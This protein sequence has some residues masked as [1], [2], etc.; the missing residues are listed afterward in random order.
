[1]ACFVRMNKLHTPYTRNNTHHAYFFLLS[2]YIDLFCKPNKTCDNVGMNVFQRHP[3]QTALILGAICVFGFAPFYIFPIPILALSGLFYLWKHTQHARQAAKIG[4]A[5]G[6]GFFT[7]GIS[8]IYISLHDVGGMPWWMA[9]TATFGLCAFLSLFHAACG[10][11]TRRI[12][13]VI[14][15]APILWT[16]LEWVREWLFTGFPWLQIGYS[17][18]PYS[19]LANLA[20][21]T[22]ILGV[23]FAVAA[24][25]SLIL[26]WQQH[27]RH[28]L[29]LWGIATLLG[30]ITWTS[31]TGQQIDVTLL[32]GNVPQTLKWDAEV[33]EQTSL[34]YYHMMQQSTADLVVM[35]E[36]ALP[37]AVPSEEI[38]Q[39]PV[40]G[41]FASYAKQHQVHVVTGAIEVE[42][43]QYY[44]SMLALLPNGTV[45]HYRKSHLVPFGEFIPFKRGLDWLYRDWLHIPMSDLSRGS[46]V[47]NFSFADMY[48][49]FNICYE[50]VFGSQIRR[51]LPQ[52]NL[53]INASNDAWYGHSLAAYQHLQF[54]QAR[55]LETGR[56]LLRATNTG[57]TAAIN[58]HGV[59]VAV[60]P[61][62][63]QASLDITAPAYTGT[64]PYVLLGNWLILVLL[65][66]ALLLLWASKN[67]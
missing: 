61:D 4:F 38:K 63:E 54:S 19:P 47:D 28:F 39:H 10:Y 8:W 17:Q 27:W 22:G 29:G 13:H 50:D 66:A 65:L 5:F 67:K 11:L 44:N 37:Y 56:W 14:W 46:A 9:A 55:A 25:A 45:Q 16:S 49:G 60:L 34:Q 24:S 40:T 12:G 58:Q 30:L 1:M 64:T 48:I 2:D 51:Q 59:V 20:S 62:F 32:Q 23:T 57:I 21:L 15:I 31:P 3:H 6:I 7:V 41:T 52:A 33:A 26:L 53:L 18:I 35:P 43:E 36:T 42:H